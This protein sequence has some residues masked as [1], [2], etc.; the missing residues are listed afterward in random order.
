MAVARPDGPAPTMRTSRTAITPHYTCAWRARCSV[1]RAQPCAPCLVLRAHASRS[2]VGARC[3]VRCLVRGAWC[4]ACARRLVWCLARGAWCGARARSAWCAF[5]IQRRAEAVDRLG[6]CARS[7]RGV[8]ML[9]RLTGRAAVGGLAGTA[10]DLQSASARVMTRYRAESPVT[11]AA[12]SLS[13]TEGAA[14]AASRSS[15]QKSAIGLQRGR[16][17]NGVYLIA[18]SGCQLPRMYPSNVFVPHAPTCKHVACRTGTRR[19][20]TAR[21]TKHDAQGTP[22]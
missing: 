17:T 8:P 6:P 10:A 4:G 13:G 11:P 19:P 5:T 7:V 14:S 9:T 15:S 16:R 18:Q 21:G 12:E 3:L 20:A 22:H 2:V 1:L